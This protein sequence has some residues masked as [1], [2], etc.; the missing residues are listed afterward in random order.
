MTDSTLIKPTES[1]LE[2]L[3]VLWEK[4][5]STVREVHDILLR[6]KEAGYTTTLKLLQIMF[7]KGL[8]SRDTANRSHVYRAAVSRERTRKQML[9]RMVRTLFAGSSSS[10]V[11]EALGH[12]QAS[13]QELEAIRAYLA[14]MDAKKKSMRK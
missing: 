3:Q 9:D 6:S 4:G 14:K 7:D 2:I 11:L 12:Y 8:V 10:L 13:E 1:E 5:P